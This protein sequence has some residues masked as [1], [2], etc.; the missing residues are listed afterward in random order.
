MAYEKF[1][2]IIVRSLI[3]I[4]IALTM[5]SCSD[6]LFGTDDNDDSSNW[7]GEIHSSNDLLEMM[8]TMDIAAYDLSVGEGS[9]GTSRAFGIVESKAAD[10]VE[11]HVGSLSIG[12]VGDWSVGA[13]FAKALRNR[14]IALSRKTDYFVEL[15]KTLDLVFEEVQ[16]PT[17]TYYFD[18]GNL[19]IPTIGLTFPTTMRVIVDENDRLALDVAMNN[20]VN[21]QMYT[22]GGN[23]G[24]PVTQIA[25]AWLNLTTGESWERLW[26]QVDRRQQ[27]LPVI[28]FEQTG[29]ISVSDL[30]T[31]RYSYLGRLIQNG[32]GETPFNIAEGALHED[33]TG[34]EDFAYVLRYRSKFD[35]EY[36]STVAYQDHIRP[37]GSNTYGP[38]AWSVETNKKVDEAV[39]GVT[40]FF[41]EIKEISQDDLP[42]IPGPDYELTV[43]KIGSIDRPLKPLSEGDPEWTVAPW[44]GV[45]PTGTEITEINLALIPGDIAPVYQPWDKYDDLT[46]FTNLAIEDTDAIYAE[47][48]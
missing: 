43:G 12:D 21:L 30:T 34:D 33:F 14:A 42:S 35:G 15:V 24:D 22:D 1:N 19:E 45:I 18:L 37:T 48:D 44:D 28:D 46:A 47:L 41:N 40:T 17:G 11:N 2:T 20:E 13:G 39:D 8:P 29:E 4:A 3:F 26:I 16:L 31:A 6:L 9:V 23:D 27:D 36:G 32:T 25:Q 10:C 38:E 5:V 7:S